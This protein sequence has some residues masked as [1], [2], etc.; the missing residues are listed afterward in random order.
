MPKRKRQA[1]IVK[2]FYNSVCPKCGEYAMYLYYTTAKTKQIAVC[3]TCFSTKAIT[4]VM[5]ETVQLTEARI[6]CD[7]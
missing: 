1:R 7:Q 3:S 5:P 2:V 6:I 4:I